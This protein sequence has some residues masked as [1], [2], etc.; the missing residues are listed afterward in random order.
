MSKETD[1]RIIIDRLLRETGWDI[2]NKSQVSTEEPAAD[3]R[4]EYLLK[5]SRTRPLAIVE[6]KRFAV[7]PYSAKDQA[8]EYAQSL[9][10]HF[11]LLSKHEGLSRN[12]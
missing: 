12:I 5:D 2:E 1:A 4:A 6:A 9:P 10:V 3:G 11:V 8:R 7:D